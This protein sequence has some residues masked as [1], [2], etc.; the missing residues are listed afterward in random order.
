M[1]FPI[2]L[3]SLASL[4]LNMLPVQSAAVPPTDLARRSE[5]SSNLA[6]FSGMVEKRHTYGVDED[7]AALEKRHTY[8]VDEDE[9]ALQKRHTHGVDE[10]EA[11]LE[12]RHT[13]GVDEDEA[14]LEKRHTYGVDKD[15][16][17]YV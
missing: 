13:Y 16:V 15:E 7:E 9:A 3:L 10:D 2:T 12:K 5:Q 4:G 14:A 17:V 8:G 11:A 1:H 6:S